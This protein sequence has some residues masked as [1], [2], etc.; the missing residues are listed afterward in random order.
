MDYR[1]RRAVIGFVYGDTPDLDGAIGGLTANGFANAMAGVAED[2]PPAAWAALLH[3]V[4]S[5]DTTRIRWTLTPGDE[6]QAAKEAPAAASEGAAGQRLGAAIELT[7]PGMANVYYGDDVGLSGQND[8]DDRRP[9]PWGHEDADL[10]A[11]YARLGELRRDREA[12]REGDLTFLAAEDATGSLAYLRRS[13]GDAALI[14]VNMDMAATLD[15]DV[16]GLLPAGLVLSDALAPVGSRDGVGARTSPRAHPRPVRPGASAAR[17]C[18]PDRAAGARRAPGA[19]A[20][21]GIV[22]LSWQPVEDAARYLV[23]RSIVPGG[24]YQLVS[25]TPAI[26]TVAADDSVPNGTTVYHVVTAVDRAGNVSARSPAVTS[27]PHAVISGLEDRR[28]GPATG[29]P[30][31]R[32]SRGPR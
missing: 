21:Q 2:Y 30:L 13:A 22:K 26:R 19:R 16:A 29:G 25:S 31:G 3:M 9:Y 8:P 17:W 15:V 12:L 20:G 5:H 27:L 11:F 28:T 24:G 10:L 7:F 6:D 32:G 1:F 23:W 18:G 14:A 4:D